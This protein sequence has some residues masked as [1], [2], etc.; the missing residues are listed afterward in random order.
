MHNLGGCAA[1]TAAVAALPF[2][3]NRIRY[4]GYR[5]QCALRDERTYNSTCS[6]AWLQP[7]KRPAPG[8]IEIRN[9]PNPGRRARSSP[10]CAR[11]WT[12]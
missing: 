9:A 2:N 5:K 6:A 1:A 10:L 7:A 11:L 3:L 12:G 4:S 8:P